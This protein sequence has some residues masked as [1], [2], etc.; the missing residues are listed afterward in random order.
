MGFFTCFCALL[1]RIV[2]LCSSERL[3]ASEYS[4]S[5][6]AEDGA[7]EGLVTGNTGVW[8]YSPWSSRCSGSDDILNHSCDPPPSGHNIY[9]ASGSSWSRITSTLCTPVQYS[10]ERSVEEVLFLGAKLD[11]LIFGELDRP[12]RSFAPI[13]GLNCLAH[14]VV[15]TSCT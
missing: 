12:V 3:L 10:P 4:Y 7:S 14:F 2:A 5:V 1:K 9:D 6:P 8:R 13:L 15:E 11:G